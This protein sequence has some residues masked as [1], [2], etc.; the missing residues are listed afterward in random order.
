MAPETGWL[1]GGRSQLELGGR[2]AMAGNRLVLAT[3]VPAP[4]DLFTS[5]PPDS[6]RTTTTSITTFP[7]RAQLLSPSQSIWIHNF[8]TTSTCATKPTNTE[9]LAMAAWLSRQRKTDLV[10]L[11]EEAGLKE[12]VSSVHRKTIRSTALLTVCSLKIASMTCAKMNSRRPLTI[13]C[14]RTHLRCR[15]SRP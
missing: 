14:A 15:T 4:R 2:S 1:G 3:G 12:S 10:T 13:I 5:T 6:R 11:A 9:I 7:H 8:G